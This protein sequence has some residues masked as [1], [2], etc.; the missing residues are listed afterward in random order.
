MACYG[1]WGSPWG[2]PWG[3]GVCYD[4]EI[5]CDPGYAVAAVALDIPEAL[6]VLY[7]D[8]GWSLAAVAV[9][10]SKSVP[11]VRCGTSESRPV[12]ISIP[13]T[14]VEHPWRFL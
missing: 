6:G 1:E 3:G 9:S 7:C 14:I 13:H 5:V 8:A 4:G 12:V 2:Q 10:I 11:S